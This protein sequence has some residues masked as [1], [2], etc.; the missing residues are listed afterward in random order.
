M[1]VYIYIYMMWA[2][3]DTSLW[4]AQIS[5][6]ASWESQKLWRGTSFQPH[7]SLCVSWL[8]FLLQSAQILHHHFVAAYRPAVF[9]ISNMPTYLQSQKQNLT[10]LNTLIKPTLYHVPSALHEHDSTRPSNSQDTRTTGVRILLC[11]DTWAVEWTS[12]ADAYTAFSLVQQPSN[13][14]ALWYS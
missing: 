8:F 5:M 3:Q 14:L 11:P 10:Y 6:I 9:Q 12:S 1:W 4:G 2:E 7:Y 13:L